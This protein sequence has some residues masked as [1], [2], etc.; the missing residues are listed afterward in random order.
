MSQ[1]IL[2]HSF[3]IIYYIS[4][5]ACFVLLLVGVIFNFI[6]P[7][8]SFICIII[9]IVITS[10]ISCGCCCGSTM[11]LKPHVKRWSTATLA[12]LC[13]MFILQIIAIIGIGIAGGR[14]VMNTG[15]VSQRTAEGSS[16]GLLVVWALTIILNFCALVFSAIFTWG[17]D[18]CVPR[19]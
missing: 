15:T 14:D 5:I 3:S 7:L 8:V 12:S 18:C 10:T 16:V 1:F 17:R 9:V 6:F 4:R 11:D 19:S 2:Y 13:L